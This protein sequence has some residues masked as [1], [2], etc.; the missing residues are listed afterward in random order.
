VTALKAGEIQGLVVQNP[1]KMGEVGVTTVVAAVQGKTVPKSV[2]TGVALAT[3]ANMSQ[4]DMQ[5][6][7]NPPIDQYLK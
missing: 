4:P 3:A 7:L 6:Y 2:D 5:E 1:F